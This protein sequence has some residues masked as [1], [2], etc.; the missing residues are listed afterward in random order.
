MSGELRKQK[1]ESEELC[2]CGKGADCVSQ[3]QVK[4]FRDENL[5]DMFSEFEGNTYHFHW[6]IE[7]RSGNSEG[8]EDGGDTQDGLK[9]VRI[10]LGWSPVL[11][12]F[13]KLHMKIF[14]SN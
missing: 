12:G 13:V 14:F 2:G 8:N 9:E 4:L 7:I 5:K 1:Y 10:D 11:T 3:K 6:H